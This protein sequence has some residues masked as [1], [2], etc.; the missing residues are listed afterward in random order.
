MFAEGMHNTMKKMNF[1]MFYVTYHFICN[2]RWQGKKIFTGLDNMSK[3]GGVLKE[4][5]TAYHL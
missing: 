1:C 2:Y 3:I 4:T 5:E